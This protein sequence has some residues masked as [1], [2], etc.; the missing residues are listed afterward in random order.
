MQY[1]EYEAV[2]DKQAIL[3][4]YR[5]AGW[6]EGGERQEEAV[7]TWV[8]AGRAYV[9]ELSGEA[10]CLVTTVPGDIRYLDESLSFANVGSVTTSR[11]ARKQGIAGRLTAVAIA[12][13]AED[14]ALVSGLGMFEQGYYNQLGFGTGGYE[15]IVSFDPAQLVVDARARVPRRIGV[16]DWA[17]VHASRLARARA[18]GSISLHPP[19]ATAAEMM[20]MKNGFGMGY[21]GGGDGEVTHHIWFTGDGWNGPYRVQWMIYRTVEQFKEL[22]ALIRTLGDQVRQITMPEPPGIQLQDMLAHPFRWRQLTEKSKFE[23]G[24]R[25]S[26]FWQV[27]VND[28]PRCLEATHLKQPSLRFN[29]RLSDPIEPYLSDDVAWRGVAGDYVVTLGPSS[30][31]ESGNDSALL[32]LDASVGAFTRMWL[33]VLPATSLA[34]T[35]QLAGSPS[36]LQQLDHMF[37][38]P[39]PH[40]D[41]DL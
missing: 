15:H 29:L 23:T 6:W 10:E 9:A 12:R 34:V 2:R 33:G 35:D 28:L 37:L 7:D 8:A 5:E 38:I 19:A 4:I 32:T 1:R 26:A 20:W 18:H 41:W 36:L 17:S 14:G 25:A 39:A 3:R 31:A 40:P 27:R 30:H 16:D 22:V 11:V 24:I 13:D 21:F